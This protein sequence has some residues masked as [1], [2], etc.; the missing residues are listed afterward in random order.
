MSRILIIDDESIIRTSLGR[1]LMR[2]G[3]EVEEADSIETAS[4][5]PLDSYDAIVSDLRLPGDPGT[6]IIS[7][8]E[9]TPVIIMTSYASVRSAVDSMRNGAVDYISKPFDH[10]EMLMMI[11]R[12]MKQHQ[13]SRQN[14]ALRSDVQRAYPSGQ[15]I[16]NCRAMRLVFERLAK[17][18]PV[19]HPVLVTGELG[20]G[21]ELIARAIHD[22]SQRANGPVIVVN[23]GAIPDDSIEAELFGYQRGAVLDEDTKRKGQADA[24]HNGTLYLSNVCELSHS[25]QARLQ[26][27]VEYGEVRAL[28]SSHARRVN[29][30]VVA[31]SPKDLAELVSSGSFREDLFLQLRGL[32]IQLPALR[33]R[34]EDITTIAN[35]ALDRASKKLNVSTQ[36]FDTH[37]LEVITRH[38]W[39]G[40]VRELINAVER[41]VI[42]S[43]D[44]V[45]DA[46]LLGIPNEPDPYSPNAQ[47][48]ADLS[49]DEYFRFFVQTNQGHMNET[50]LAAKL[51]M[52]RKA[53][54]ERRQR[55]DLPRRAVT[56]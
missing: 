19:E 28:G 30:R 50:E 51:G 55:M 35:H 37:T 49:L 33:D 46:G 29:V 27:L 53:L 1:M 56:P 36:P 48:S 3:Y 39:P 42:L 38:N 12:S 20:T 17:I 23:C 54:W 18:A 45:I 6:S 2:N 16:G 26:R 7:L 43:N 22:S 40:N 52:S 44:G 24:A 15:M 14:A 9:N 41:A 47:L 10:D 11:E 25:A 21:K 8:V 34:A 32:E 4:T 31:S 13:L 5:L